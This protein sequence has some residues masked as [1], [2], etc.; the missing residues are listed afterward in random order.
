[1]TE[2]QPKKGAERFLEE[3]LAAGAEAGFKALAASNGMDPA[4]AD[5]AMIAKAGGKLAGRGAALAVGHAKK[6]VLALFTD[7]VAKKLREL[8][9]EAATEALEVK[10]TE[11]L[12]DAETDEE[13]AHVFAA[14][15]ATTRSWGDAQAKVADGK[16]RRLLLAALVHAFDRESYEEGL[17]LRVMECLERL[18]YAAVRLLADLETELPRGRLFRGGDLSLDAFHGEQLA[19]QRLVVVYDRSQAGDRGF[20]CSEFG[21]VLLRYVRE[22]L[23]AD[24]SLEEPE[25][26]GA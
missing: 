16:K 15:E 17:S 3:V 26:Q 22:Q 14:V 23:Q 20:K 12:E 7:P 10:V 25:K 11:R 9:L 8:E 4:G 2:E 24:L 19:E 1:V 13:K 5:T 18:D 21:Q 6:T